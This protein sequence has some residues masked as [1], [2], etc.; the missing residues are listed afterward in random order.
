V[1]RIGIVGGAGFLGTNLALRARSSGHEVV[2]IDVADRLGR[3]SHSGL[4]DSVD[5][6]FVNLAAEDATITHIRV[7]VLVHLAALAQVDFS[8]FHPE[9][10]VLNN[11]RALTTTLTAARL[12]RTPVLFASS[13]EVYGG[14]DG[15]LY[16]EIDA[17]LALSPYA[18]SKIGGE[19]ILESFRVAFDVRATTVRLTNLYGPWQAPDRVIPRITL[20]ALVKEPSQATSGRVRDFLFVDDAVNALLSL[21]ELERWGDTLNVAAGRGTSLE[22]VAKTIIDMVG[23]GSYETVECPTFDGRGYSLVASPD[24]LTAATGWLPSVSLESGIT[25]TVAWYRQNRAWWTQFESVVRARR[26]TPD[27]LVDHVRPVVA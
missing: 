17:P 13:V 21:I 10:T 20:Q 27:F 19:H 11:I 1:S 24:R 8:L 18:A 3:L 5:C 25:E 9:V 22:A 6:R 14:N 7:D 15:A 2:V 4:L 26:E 23:S 16:R 12:T